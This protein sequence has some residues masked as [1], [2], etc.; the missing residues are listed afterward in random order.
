[1]AS[2]IL[3]TAAESLAA[4]GYETQISSP[5]AYY[6]F[7]E[8]KIDFFSIAI[9]D[10]EMAN[11]SEIG[12]VK[13]AVGG[14][15]RGKSAAA[16]I[17]AGL[18]D[19][20]IK[21]SI[22]ASGAAGLKIRVTG[23]RAVAYLQNYPVNELLPSARPAAEAFK[24]RPALY[25]IKSGGAWLPDMDYMVKLSEARTGDL[26]QDAETFIL[27]EQIW[28]LSQYKEFERLPSINNG[29]YI[30]GLNNLSGDNDARAQFEKKIMLAPDHFYSCLLDFKAGRYK[31]SY[32]HISACRALAGGN[33]IVETV[34]NMILTH[35]KF[36]RLISEEFVNSYRKDP[37]NYLALM[38]IGEF[39][40]LRFRYDQ[41]LMA[42]ELASS[43]NPFMTPHYHIV[44]ANTYEKLKNYTAAGDQLSICSSYGPDFYYTR[45]LAG[46]KYIMGGDEKKAAREFEAVIDSLN[47][48]E[49]KR[50]VAYW[51]MNYHW[52]NDNSESYYLYRRAYITSF[53]NSPMF[54]FLLG[55]LWLV[56]MLRKAAARYIMIPVLKALAKIFNKEIFYNKTFDAYCNFADC[57]TGINYYAAYAKSV[58]KKRF[59]EVYERSALKLA[60][61]LLSVYRPEEAKKIYTELFSF[62]PDCVEAL[63]GLAISEYDLKNY[64]VALEYFKS[65]IESA[66]DN[67]LFYYYAGICTMLDGMKKEAIELIMISYKINSSFEPALGLCNNYFLANNMIGELVSFYDDIFVLGDFSESYIQYYLKLNVSRMDSARIK[68]MLDKVRGMKIVKPETC[69]EAAVA[70][71]ELDL[72]DEAAGYIYKSI[73]I[74]AGYKWL[75]GFKTL[76][77]L[78]RAAMLLPYYKNGR[79]SKIQLLELGITYKK[80]NDIKK[81]EEI[82]K[83]IIKSFPDHAYAH[84]LLNNYN[85]SIELMAAE[86]SESNYPWNN[87][88]IVEAIFYCLKETNNR[89]RLDRYREWGVH[90]ARSISNE[91]G[92]FSYRHLRYIPKT[93]FLNTINDNEGG[94]KI[95]S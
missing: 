71:R 90:Y 81:A 48:A 72:F 80:N 44:F 27:A 11:S 18:F 20:T 77:I 61:Y 39:Y 4:G 13:A 40:N 21:D 83:K 82:F 2:V 15:R 24:I 38:A 12:A 36:G 43:L 41:S 69:L 34:F 35:R 47:F 51:L 59:P 66:V 74:S 91:F 88:S 78:E 56:Y 33:F 17:R 68:K 53:F 73:L 52:K 1:M 8:R 60:N 6:S 29:D 26:Y 87:A 64:E 85:R 5:P 10:Y 19:E 28:L 58:D 16:L 23:S 45:Y 95:N 93:Q 75:S 94:L 57:E 54:I 42:F 55:I 67:H 31:H 25:L 14:F 92:I 70:C 46:K 84:F 86:L 63:L 50:E 49:T 79:Y 37:Y 9:N 76:E 32:S 7:E 3:V 22:L 65:G 89:Q 62:R 30:S